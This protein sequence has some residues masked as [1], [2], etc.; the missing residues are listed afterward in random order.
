[1]A[2]AARANCSAGS[3]RTRR[4]CCSRSCRRLNRATVDAL[5]RP[6]SATDNATTAAVTPIENPRPSHQVSR[7][8]FQ[9]A[10]ATG[11]AECTQRQV[12]TQPACKSRTPSS[13]LSTASHGEGR[14]LN[15]LA[16][17]SRQL[18]APPPLV[19]LDDRDHPVPRPVRVRCAGSQLSSS[20][21]LDDHI[22]GQSGV[23]GRQRQVDPVIARQGCERAKIHDLLIDGP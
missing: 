11:T 6:S 20:D 9:R 4:A 16:E 14:H 22:D 10:I 3:R 2:R 15:A 1:V 12:R 13:E 7:V 8:A 21:G 23:V 19:N 17:A 5:A 18:S